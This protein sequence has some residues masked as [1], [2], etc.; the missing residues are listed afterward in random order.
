VR[1]NFVKPEDTRDKR[2]LGTSDVFVSPLGLGCVQFSRG[3]GISGLLWPPLN[4]SDIR[5]IVRASLEG[6]I[7]WFDTAELYGW[8][9]SEKALALALGELNVP[10]GDVVLATKW[11]PVL[12]R[13]GS[14][15][16][17]IDDRLRF[18]GTD[19]ID[20][21][22][23]HN[24]Y[25]F[26]STGSQMREMAKLAEDGKVR[27][28]GVSNFTADG[29]RKAHLELSWLGLA[30]VSNQVNY[31]LLRREI[32]TNG[33]LDAAEDLGVTIIAYSPL[34]RGL[35]T[36]K[37]HERPELLRER[38][39]FRRYYGSLSRDRLRESGPVAEALG[40]VAV[41]YG[42]TPS[43]VALNWLMNFHGETVV[44]IPGATTAEQA[45]DNAGAMNFRL[46]DD[47]LSYLDEV[48][49]NFK[50]KDQR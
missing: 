16:R 20:L 28:A 40:T 31:S 1:L 32:E 47:D 13:A 34:A 7:N 24:P 10:R 43:Q 49:A 50:Y 29:M 11:W 6:G 42:A 44:V 21:H 8:G 25:S 14:I 46:S 26:S 27:Y 39:I 45:R 3:K 30:L 37:F 38:N 23:V 2:R 35:L 9:E 48:S 22:Q 18:L 4:R 5:D 19:Y 17:T 15:G 36:G 12:R 33:V 41:K